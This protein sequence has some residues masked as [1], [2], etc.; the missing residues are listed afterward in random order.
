M[1]KSSLESKLKW[2]TFGF[3]LNLVALSFIA[4]SLI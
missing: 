3:M 1:T 2:A 4:G